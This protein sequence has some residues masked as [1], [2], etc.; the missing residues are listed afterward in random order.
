MSKVYYEVHMTRVLHT[1]LNSA[2]VSML[3]KGLNFAVTPASILA[4]EII[5]N[6][7]SAVR[8]LNVEQADNVR[9]AVNDILTALKKT[10]RS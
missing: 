6:V 7:E 3:K 8:P 5:A 4:T 9:K 10:T 2:E 1:C